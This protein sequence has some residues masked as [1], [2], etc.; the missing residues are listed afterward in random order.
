MVVEWVVLF[1]SFSF[2]SKSKLSLNGVPDVDALDEAA[3]VVEEEIAVN[4]GG[5]VSVLVF[6]EKLKGVLGM[7]IAVL[8]CVVFKSKLQMKR[9]RRIDSGLIGSRI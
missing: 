8:K 7:G 5:L 6:G 4:G 1:V 2:R 3:D 9:C